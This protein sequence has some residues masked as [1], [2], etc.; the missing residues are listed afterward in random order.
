MIIFNDFAKINHEVLEVSYLKAGKEYMLKF[1]SLHF[2]INNYTSFDNI[3][4]SFTTIVMTNFNEI[5]P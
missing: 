1:P 2:F 4:R 3:F 5:I